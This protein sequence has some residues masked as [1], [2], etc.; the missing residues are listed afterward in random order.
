MKRIL[1]LLVT[2]VS[3]LNASAQETD[4]LK[5][6]SSANLVDSLSLRLNKL[7]NDYDYL[8]C[9]YELNKLIMELQDLSHS[10]RISAN[11]VVIQLY[12]SSYDRD[13]YVSYLKDYESSGKCLDSLKEKI[14]VVR[15]RVL[16]KIASS[17]F[18]DQEMGVL[19]S[20]FDVIQA[21]VSAV[22]SA[23]GFYDIAIEAY[24]KKR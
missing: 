10:I 5:C 1:I 23:L 4:S 13:L 3:V 24:R 22:E 11:E 9:D 6:Q 16:F 18:S 14:D 12:N 20:S 7:Q 8:C 21:G 17:V 15:I 2:I 19:Y